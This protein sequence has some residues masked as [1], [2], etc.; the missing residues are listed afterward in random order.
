[1]KMKTLAFA[2]SLG[3]LFGCMSTRDGQVGERAVEIEVVGAREHLG[4][5]TSTEGVHSVWCDGVRAR[6]VKTGEPL[7][8]Y[9]INFRIEGTPYRFEQG[10]RYL[11]RFKGGEGEG[12]MGYAGRCI[13]LEQVTSLQPR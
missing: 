7:V 1:M 6:D 12:V 2:L 13:D 3:A 8:V 4:H 10:R 11:V 9:W 5:D